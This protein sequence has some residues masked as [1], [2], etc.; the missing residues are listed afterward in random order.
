MSGGAATGAGQQLSGKQSAG[1]G[2]PTLKEKLTQESCGSN[3]AGGSVIPGAATS[4]NVYVE[5]S[6]VCCRFTI[7]TKGFSSVAAVMDSIATAVPPLMLIFAGVSATERASFSKVSASCL[8][9]TD[10]PTSSR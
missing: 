2:Q 4:A 3:P 9:Q 5:E 7:K 10:V 8:P 1:V 6:P